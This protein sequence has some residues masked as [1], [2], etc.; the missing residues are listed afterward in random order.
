[1]EDGVLLLRMQEVVMCDEGAETRAQLQ[2]LGGATP[3]ARILL[4]A[5]SVCTRVCLVPMR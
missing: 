3:T 5:I 4:C 2:V 1:M